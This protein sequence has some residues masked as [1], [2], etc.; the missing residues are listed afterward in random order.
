MVN[1]SNETA[2]AARRGPGA[3]RA[4]EVMLCLLTAPLWGL[5]VVLLATLVRLVDGAPAFFRQERAG[6]GGSPFILVKLRTMRTG[7]GSDAARLT[8]LGRVL[9]RTSLD[10][11]PELWQVLTGRLALVGPRPLP[12]RY[13]PR[14]TPEQMRRHDVRPGLTGWAQVHGRNALS[15]EDRFQLDVWY[16]AHRTFWLDMRI[17][18]MTVGQVLAGRGV[19]ADDEAT[20]HEFQGAA[21]QSAKS[22]K[23][24]QANT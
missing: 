21:A 23:K 19:A 6:L 12:V 8:R 2:G 5:L 22:G 16:A 15:W 7:E 24:R 3:M 17:L 11:L 9:R 1:P 18:G 13:L 14:Y 20:M 4:V 10:E